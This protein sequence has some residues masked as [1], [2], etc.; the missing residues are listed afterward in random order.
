MSSAPASRESS[1]SVAS[2][3]QLESVLN[4]AKKV[5]TV[6]EAT[7]T[8]Q[9][10]SSNYAATSTT[11]HKK[12]SAPTKKSVPAKKQVVLNFD[13][14]GSKP[15]QKKAD[16]KKRVKEKS[17][18]QVQIDDELMYDEEPVF[19][20]RPTK[21][22]VVD[23]QT[24][25][26]DNKSPQGNLSLPVKSDTDNSELNEP[27]E[28]S[29]RQK[30][31][32]IPRKHM[33]KVEQKRLQW[34]LENAALEKLRTEHGRWAK[35]IDQENTNQQPTVQVEKKV[36]HV[37][38]GDVSKTK[39]DEKQL[40]VKS[41]TAAHKIMVEPDFVPGLGSISTAAVPA[42]VSKYSDPSAKAENVQ[43]KPTEVPAMTTLTKAQQKRMQWERERGGESIK[44]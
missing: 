35:L 29:P 43:V 41:T 8:N 38:H 12:H 9:K 33:T 2:S 23:E 37:S 11:E 17:K 10:D 3:S 5:K 18:K 13:L 20:R 39:G 40:D 22:V 1:K 16:G 15:T 7:E 4:L 19:V 34:E 14:S 6:G 30:H 36:A 24:T 27:K 44:P 31:L 26:R 28:L 21:V 42:Q 32:L 25:P